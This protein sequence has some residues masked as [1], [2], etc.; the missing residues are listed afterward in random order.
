MYLVLQIGRGRRFARGTRNA[1]KSPLACLVSSPISGVGEVA[2][3]KSP[4]GCGN[5]NCFNEPH[6]VNDDD[7]WADY[8]LAGGPEGVM[9]LN[10]PKTAKSLGFVVKIDDIPVSQ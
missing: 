4:L 9:Q 5:G 2:R 8:G 1:N 10:T 6:G 3:P 7:Y